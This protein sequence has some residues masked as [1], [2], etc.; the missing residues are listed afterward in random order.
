MNLDN[1][2]HQTDTSEIK[3]KR[4]IVCNRIKLQQITEFT[5]CTVVVDS[6]SNSTSR[7]LTDDVLYYIPA[8]TSSKI[9]T[10]DNGRDIAGYIRYVTTKIQYNSPKELWIHTIATALVK[11][12][13]RIW[14]KPLWPSGT[15]SDNVLVH[16]MAPNNNLYQCWVNTSLAPSESNFKRDTSANNHLS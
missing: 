12:C 15:G 6:T 4:R 5:T 10:C 3:E 8:D 9:Q 2:L 1:N 13:W 14:V 16:V 7:S 11:Q